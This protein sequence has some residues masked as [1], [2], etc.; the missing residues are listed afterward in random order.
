[1]I[2]RIAGLCFLCLYLSTA[3]RVFSAEWIVPDDV[4][5]IQAAVAAADPGDDIIVRDGTHSGGITVDKK[6]LTIR[7]ENGSIACILNSGG[8]G[9]GFYVT[10]DGVTVDGF[11]INNTGS[12]EA[13]FLFRADGCVIRNNHITE[14]GADY[15]AIGLYDAHAN[16]IAD[17][18]L[19]ENEM[20][21]IFL[22]CSRDNHITGNTI[23]ANQYGS[24]IY[25]DQ[26]AASGEIYQSTGN[27][28]SGNSIR[29]C[30][31]YQRSGMAAIK[32][33]V[34][35]HNT[36]H[37]NIVEDNFRALVLLG[38]GDNTIHSNTF[39]NNSG[40]DLYLQTA[41]PNVSCVG[42]LIYNNDFDV[43]GENVDT[44]SGSGS[45]NTW[46]IDKT[47]GVNILGGPYLGGNAWSS[48]TGPDAD[49]DCLGD[50]SRIVTQTE[51]GLDHLPLVR[52]CQSGPTDP[53]I[54]TNGIDDDGDGL[55]DCADPDCSGLAGGPAGQLCE[56]GMERTCNDGFDNNG[57]GWADCS[58][59]DC[60]G[61][62]N[63]IDADDDGFSAD[64]DCDDGNA[65]VY[66]GAFERCDGIDN[67]CDG[68]IDEDGACDDA[69]DDGV[70]DYADNCPDIP[71]PGQED[72]DGDG[73]GDACDDDADGDGVSDGADNCPRARNPGQED[74][75][76]DGV[77]D[78]CDQCPDIPNS[79]PP[80]DSDVFRSLGGPPTDAPDG[81]WDE[82]D[83]CPA[84]PNGP[85]RGTCTSGHTGYWCRNDGECGPDALPGAC[86]M[87]QE[88]TD[89]D[90]IGDVCDNC[91]NMSNPA[92]DDADSDGVGDGCDNCPHHNNHDQLDAD[93]DGLGNAC[94]NCPTALNP[95]QSDTDCRG[96]PP[97]LSEI[98]VPWPDGVGDVCDNCRYTYNPDQVDTDGDGMGDACD[99]C[100]AVVNHDQQDTMDA[101]AYWRFEEG[102][103]RTAAD[104]GSG[105]YDG[106]LNFL[107]LEPIR[108]VEGK[109]GGGLELG[110]Y[111]DTYVETPL[112]LDQSSGSSGY[113]I[114]LW[115]KPT[116]LSMAVPIVTTK[117]ALARCAWGIYFDD[118]GGDPAWYLYTGGNSPSCTYQHAAPADMH[119]WQHL[120]ASFEP[121]VGV[122]FYKNGMEIENVADLG[123]A[124]T[125]Y[126][127]LLNIGGA[128][129][130]WSFD[131]VIDEVA[132]FQGVLPHHIIVRLYEESLAASHYAAAADG[133]GD[134]CDNCPYS[135]NPDQSDTDGDG[136]GDT[137]DDDADGDG[138]RNVY[139][140]N[141]LASNDADTDGDGD[142]DDCDNCP[143]LSNPDQSD[144]DRDG[145][146][147]VCDNCVD[148]YNPDQIDRDDDGHG[149]VCDPCYNDPEGIDSDG[150]GITDVCDNCPYVSN[151]FQSDL[152]RDGIGDDCDNCM[153]RWNFSQNDMDGDGVGDN[154]DEDRDDDGCPDII[155][156]NPEIRNAADADGDGVPLDCDNCPEHSNPDQADFDGDGVGDACDCD[157]FFTGVNED[158][159]DCGGICG[160]PCPDLPSGM[161]N[162]EPIRL[163]GG[164]HEGVIDLV[165]IAMES[166]IGDT[167]QFRDDVVDVIRTRYLTLGDHV[168]GYRLRSD[169]RDM[170]NFY[171]YT[172]GFGL[173]TGCSG[174]FPTGF[175]ADAP[176]R[177]TAALLYNADGGG[178]CA[179]GLAPPSKFK[180]PGRSKGVIIHESGHAVWGLIDEYCGDTSY[181]SSELDAMPFNNIWNSQSDCLIEASAEGWSGG[182]CREIDDHSTGD[183]PS[184]MW[185]YDREW[186]VMHGQM[187]SPETDFDMACSR[188]IQHVF[189]TWPTSDSAGVLLSLHLS[190]SGEVSLI[191]AHR[192][193]GHPDL[194]MQHGPFSAA[195][196]LQDGTVV[197]QF[198]IRDP[199]IEF[200]EN[201]VVSGSADFDV[202]VPY[203]DGY[204]HVTITDD[205]TGSELLSVPIHSVE[206]CANGDDDDGDGL[207]DCLD[208][209]CSQ[210]LCDDGDPHTNSRCISGG[211]RAVVEG[212]CSDGIDND[213][214]GDG[215]CADFNCQGRSCAD[216][217]PCTAT[218]TG[219]TPVCRD[220]RCAGS[221][222]ICCDDGLDNNANGLTDCEDSSCRGRECTGPEGTGGV[223]RCYRDRCV[224]ITETACGDGID[225]DEDGLVDCADAD[226][227]D[228]SC[229]DSPYCNGED[230]R[231]L[232]G[233]C[234]PQTPSDPASTSGNGS[235]GK[236]SSCF[237]QS[238]N[239]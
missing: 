88:D 69:D 108:W 17:N 195:I 123:I 197:Q 62:P 92:Q 141:P 199:R 47:A 103:E 82:C 49:G 15:G 220:G 229:N 22:R 228:V 30:A 94:D 178:G 52:D 44:T 169:Y 130:G 60:G 106:H 55:I 219:E 91:P 96:G 89:G 59:V 146:G 156:K 56:H 189:D 31:Y 70:V 126:G 205:T 171:I 65:L 25:L 177:D 149:D 172:G 190:D 76:G 110:G 142:I 166:Y 51:A 67:D 239:D 18:T 155:D 186:C 215:D 152:D 165:F 36:V 32:L 3:P 148:A 161:E 68:S 124:Q 81:V 23:T 196:K 95:G 203:H 74:L 158:R 150:D 48:Y 122:R 207:V 214:D 43:T 13:V 201:L 170:Y 151:L 46:N 11:T 181:H 119:A 80:Q 6:D 50:T 210:A 192:V 235:G 102:D 187:R 99:N 212:N 193:D 57:D 37:G 54:C 90:G 86:S 226:C 232:N 125:R 19:H 137:C 175:N 120:A 75:D 180:A 236:N 114:M 71:N 164:F 112:V 127:G 29:D 167:A 154:C 132:V 40:A 144:T 138:C 64:S 160:V 173:S 168:T 66:P 100:P 41:Y 221:I 72:T 176:N 222:E 157:D 153:D 9:R 209:D 5:T 104:F 191:K 26:C 234:T 109:V 20:D 134:T 61:A 116:A 136:S 216:M 129:Y 7:S 117:T 1:M 39:R 113:T 42:N 10:V 231:C 107:R 21:A 233:E 45:S 223:G 179:N 27:T 218:A 159:P 163:R 147:N 73:V 53:E 14:N 140:R 63:C 38:A 224:G 208:P 16:T 162:V 135:W 143:Y 34:A 85:D 98:C 4:A 12:A 139:D 128:R 58:D 211:C 206:D 217:D 238:L 84:T 24:G 35:N 33:A 83:N 8:S 93:N 202:I 230:C 188:Q 225:N 115:V 237:V 111:Y 131:G 28:L 121:G 204:H 145:V 118:R 182:E 78:V 198:E 2:G 105:L 97:E 185:K 79:K 87:H 227:R 101:L 183:C 200:S 194:G 133:V 174:T 213:G 184:D 77:G